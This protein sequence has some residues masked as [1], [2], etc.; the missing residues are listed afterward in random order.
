MKN[1]KTFIHQAA[2][3]AACIL[4]LFNNVNAQTGAFISAMPR[5]NH[6]NTYSGRHPSSFQYQQMPISMNYLIGIEQ[7]ITS[8]FSAQIGL[9][10]NNQKYVSKIYTGRNFDTDEYGY[11]SGSNEN[12]LLGLFLNLKQVLYRK[13]T[14]DVY[15]GAGANYVLQKPIDLMENTI[16]LSD[17]D[18]TTN[19][20]DT[21]LT[22]RALISRHPDFRPF[23]AHAQLGVSKRFKNNLTI[24]AAAF[25][26]YAPPVYR[27]E[28]TIR[29][30]N[31]TYQSQS[32]LLGYFGAL[33][34]SVSYPIIRNKL[35]LLKKK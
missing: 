7:A 31:N 23:A 28:N 4:L 10:Q 15:L 21:V 8:S 20:V 25:F 12:S 29:W 34:L 18:E 1:L 3:I 17:F 27:I 24:S 35:H 13:N 22:T 26:Y 30:E 14:F 2:I 6:L 19:R 32:E 5:S 11:G 9:M 33:N 16:S